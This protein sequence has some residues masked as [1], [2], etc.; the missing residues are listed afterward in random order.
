MLEA[1]LFWRLSQDYHDMCMRIC[2]LCQWRVTWDWQQCLLCLGGSVTDP[3]CFFLMFC[4]SWQTPWKAEYCIYTP[5]LP[6]VN[7]VPLYTRRRESRIINSWRM[8]CF[9]LLFFGASPRIIMIC[10]CESANCASDALHGIDSSASPYLFKSCGL[11]WILS[12]FQVTKEF[13]MRRPPQV[14]RNFI[15]LEVRHLGKL[16][17]MP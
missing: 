15:W 3:L 13:S 12:S 5:D 16:R 8:Q 9:K 11:C 14:S 6:C 10:A 7:V 2:K 17:E 1:A 4:S